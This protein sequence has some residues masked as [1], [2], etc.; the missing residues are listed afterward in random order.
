[1]ANDDAFIAHRVRVETKLL[2]VV[3]WV[4]AAVII[5]LTGAFLYVRS[6]FNSANITNVREISKLGGQLDALETIVKSSKNDLLI[7]KKI[8]I[9]DDDAGRTTIMPGSIILEDA[10]KIRV[11]LTVGIEGP[12]IG[13]YDEKSTVR[14]QLGVNTLTDTKVGGSEITPES[15]LVLYDKDGKVSLRF[16][17]RR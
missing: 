13:I 9:G 2:R 1:M 8:T 6:S 10:G 4:L 16:P 7:A 12:F 17:V 11:M 15:C 14:A 3:I 5:L